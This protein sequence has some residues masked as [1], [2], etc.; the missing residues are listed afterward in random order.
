[1]DIKDKIITV[2]GLNTLHEYNKNTYSTILDTIAQFSN[3]SRILSGSGKNL[4]KNTAVTTLKN[5]VMFDINDDKTVT[6]NDTAIDYTYVK[7]GEFEVKAGESYRISGCP[8]GGNSTS[9]YFTLIM[10][11]TNLFE[12][13]DGLVITPTVDEVKGY[14]VAVRQGCTVNNLVFKPMVTLANVLNQEYEPYTETVSEKIA[15]FSEGEW[16]LLN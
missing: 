12:T 1:M 3:Q 8:A 9:G 4:V 7:I 14:Y 15:T 11:T 10:G 16:E 13:G 6:I 5:G 2:D